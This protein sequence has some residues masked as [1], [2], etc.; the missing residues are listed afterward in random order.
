MYQL[1]QSDPDS[2]DGRVVLSP[3]FSPGEVVATP[4]ALAALQEHE[5]SPLTLLARHL[6]GDWGDV[7]AEDAQLNNR[8]LECGDRLLSSYNLGGD[9]RI[10]IISEWDRSVTTLLLPSEY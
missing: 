5:V 6:S 1:I 2:P 7:P 3:K 4:A 9:V 10:W 8:G